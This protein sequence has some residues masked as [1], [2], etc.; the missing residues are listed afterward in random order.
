L[1]GIDGVRL[2]NLHSG[3]PARAAHPERPWPDTYRTE[4]ARQRT[5]LHI[6]RLENFMYPLVTLVILVVFGA[7]LSLLPR[8]LLKGYGH[9]FPLRHGRG[10]QVGLTVLATI[11]RSML[12]IT[13]LNPPQAPRMEEVDAGVVALVACAGV[14]DILRFWRA[15]RAA[16]LKQADDD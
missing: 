10:V 16:M 14:Y 3:R 9:A 12:V 8:S 2:E 15:L 13:Q 1:E 11:T 5:A 4:T 6:G 7:F